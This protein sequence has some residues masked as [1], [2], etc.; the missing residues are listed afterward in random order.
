M[1]AY[2]SNGPKQC[3]NCQR[4]NHS[5]DTC[6][7]KPAYMKCAG[8]HVTRECKSENL[9]IKCA[10]CNEP[11]TANYGGCKFNP[12]NVKN[13]RITKLRNSQNSFHSNN[14]KPT[15][16]YSKMASGE[17]QNANAPIVQSPSI[18]NLE[19]FPPLLNSNNNNLPNN[20][21]SI[22]NLDNI[23]QKLEKLYELLVKINNIPNS[24]LA[25]LFAQHMTGE[26]S[27]KS[28]N[29]KP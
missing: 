10:N 12:R 15:L 20:I 8:S 19:E 18:L 1:E 3:W 4:F 16:S 27:N 11:H 17:P 23:I 28:Q 29:I 7:F 26:S 25:T 2:R 22:E 13:N 14:V 5:S 24:S 6:H 21:P 9:T